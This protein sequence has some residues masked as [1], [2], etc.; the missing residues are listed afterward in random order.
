MRILEVKNVI[1]PVAA[2]PYGQPEPVVSDHCSRWSMSVE[3]E[4]VCHPF[5]HHKAV[6][7]EW[8]TSAVPYHGNSTFVDF[9]TTLNL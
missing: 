1:D 7:S 3:I 6:W 4:L 2:E 9:Y 8:N 5:G